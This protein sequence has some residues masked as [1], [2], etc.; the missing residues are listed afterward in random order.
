M[1]KLTGVGK[2]F[3]SRVVLR[4]ISFAATASSI[5]LLVGTNGAGK[6]TLLRIIAGLSKPSVGTVERHCDPRE[7]GYL[8]HATFIYPGL[9]ALENLAFWSGLYGIAHDRSSLIALLKRVELSRFAEE[10]AGTFSRGMSQRLNLAR[11]LLQS[12]RVLLLDEPDTGLDTHSLALLHKE[13]IH[14]K[15]MGA[16]VVWIT[17]DWEHDAAYADRILAISHKTLAYDGPTINWPGMEKLET[18][19]ERE[20]HNQQRDNTSGSFIC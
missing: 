16:C 8:G 10:Q 9:S 20:K 3:G 18:S 15:T 4:N 1:L 14:A 2:L 12:P 5:N 6:T 19:Y 17:H 13:I 11:V 7:L